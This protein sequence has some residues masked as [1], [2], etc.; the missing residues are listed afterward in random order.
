MTKKARIAELEQRI[1]QLE[2]ELANLRG[3]PMLLCGRVPHPMIPARPSDNPCPG[4]PGPHY[5]DPHRSSTGDPL[6]EPPST[7]CAADV[8]HSVLPKSSPPRFI[9]C[10]PADTE[11]VRH[12]V[13]ATFG[14]PSMADTRQAIEALSVWEPDGTITSLL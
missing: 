7:I 1:E 9:V 8:T 14:F 10:K 2:T 5:W 3:Q 11:A 6:P 13:D 4:E 12:A